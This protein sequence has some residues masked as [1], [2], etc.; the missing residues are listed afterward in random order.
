VVVE[1]SDEPSA[2]ER[3]WD[4]SGSVSLDSSVAYLEHHSTTRT[5]YTGLTKLRSRLNLELDVDL[6]VEGWKARASGFVWYDFAY[7]ANGRDGYTRDV[8]DVYELH[9]EL[10]ETWLQ[11]TLFERLDVKIG[12]QIVN[13]GRSDNIRVVDVLNPLDNTEPGLADI[14]DLRR[15]VTMLRFDYRVSPDWTLQGIAIPEIRLDRNPPYG[16]DYYFL[17]V[18]LPPR[19]KPSNTELAASVHGIF[20]GWDVSFYYANVY[21]DFARIEP[22]PPPAPQGSFQRHHNRLNMAGSGANYT[23]GSWLAKGEIAWFGGTEY[24]LVPGPPEPPR[25]DE[26]SRLDAMLGVEYYGIIDSTFAFE[27]VNRHIF[28]YDDSILQTQFTRENEVI[29]SF[30]YTGDWLRTRLR[31][32]LVA[33]LFG[34]RVQ[35]G[36]IV[37]IQADYTFLDGLVGTA[38]IVLYQGGDLLP[39]SAWNSNDRLFFGLRYSF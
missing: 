33:L 21:E 32:T 2:P 13:W 25:T 4:L 5:D 22:A 37:R 29:W 39:L 6:P 1:E 24:L 35:D 17:P 34:Y 36:A 9:A 19:D 14:E 28:D 27:A 8:L 38:G 10:Q 26:K 11:G 15:A 20:S 18:P 3:W 31:T 16:S 7:L 12:R 23:I 30:R